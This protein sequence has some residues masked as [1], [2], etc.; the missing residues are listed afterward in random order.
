V[1]LCRGNAKGRRNKSEDLRRN[2]TEKNMSPE[3]ANDIKGGAFN[4]T[5][6]VTI[7]FEAR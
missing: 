3:E 7:P 4:S 2:E 5:G 6:S 1:D